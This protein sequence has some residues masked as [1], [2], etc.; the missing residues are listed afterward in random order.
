MAMSEREI[1]IWLE[2][3]QHARN[4]PATVLMNA[5]LNARDRIFH[6]EYEMKTMDKRTKEYVEKQK[7]VALNKVYMPELKVA[8]KVVTGKEIPY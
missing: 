4:F 8:Y 1:Q 5:Y 3:N 7:E 6:C 2:N